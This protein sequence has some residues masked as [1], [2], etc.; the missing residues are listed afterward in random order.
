[1]TIALINNIPAVSLAKNP[2]AVKLQTDAFI[3]SAGTKCTVILDFNSGEASQS[4]TF[5]FNYTKISD[6]QLF[7]FRNAPNNSGLQLPAFVSGD[8]HEWLDSIVLYLYKNY[9]LKRDWTIERVDETISM[10]AKFAGTEYNVTGVN[11]VVNMLYVVNNGTDTVVEDNF[12]IVL[13]IFMISM[14]FF[15]LPKSFYPKLQGISPP[16]C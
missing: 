7:T 4:E 11:N 15:R 13:D 12:S 5:T 8:K 1:M 9:Y 6:E 3:S 14:L 2:I 16:I 10:E